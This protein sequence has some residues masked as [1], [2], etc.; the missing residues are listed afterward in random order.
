[1]MSFSLTESIHADEGLPELLEALAIYDQGDDQSAVK[2]LTPLAE[3]GNITAIFKLANSHSNLGNRDQ[4]K[5]LYQLG[6]EFGDIRCMNNLAGILNREGDAEAAFKLYEEAAESGQAE[7]TYNFAVRLKNLGQIPAAIKWAEKSLE[8]GYVRAP[9]LLSVLLQSEVDRFH[10]LGL[11]MNSMTSLGLELGKLMT[12]GNFTE[13]LELVERVNLEQV[14]STELNQLG[15]FCLGAGNLYFNLDR[16]EEAAK[17]FELALVPGHGLPAAE[18]ENAKQQLESCS[19]QRES[20]ISLDYSETQATPVP[21][22]GSALDIVDIVR[23][24]AFI[25]SEGSENP[26]LRQVIEAENIS[27]PLAYAQ[28]FG[29]VHLTEKGESE[30]R[31]TYD[32]FASKALELGLDDLHDLLFVEEPIAQR[33]MTIKLESEDTSDA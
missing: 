31:N 27:L 14:Q 26:N 15:W 16:F 23:F 3:S 25:S 19:E 5:E 32:F 9:A 2:L 13:A 4:A 24:L 29:Y 6:V 22:D 30:L 12:A 28:E 18:I 1:M 20:E 33:P 10:K 21:Q 8:A 17:Y 11:E 7:P